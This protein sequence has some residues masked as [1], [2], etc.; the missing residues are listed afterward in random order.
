KIPRLIGKNGS[1]IR[2]LNGITTCK[3]FV[4]QNGIVWVKGKNHDDERIILKAIKK[5]EKE[6]HTFGLTDRI[7]EYIKNEKTKL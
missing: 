3:I 5:I 1:M 4:A 7:K 2:M 6:A